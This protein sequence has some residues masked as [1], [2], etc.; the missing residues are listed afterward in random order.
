VNHPITI[1]V[2]V[3]A[4]RKTRNVAL[5]KELASGGA[6]TVYQVAGEPATVVKLYHSETLRQVGKEYADK[7]FCLLQN[8][9]SL[10]SSAAGIIQLSWPFAMARDVSGNFVGFAM[11][12]LDFNKTES[13]ECILVPKMAGQK[14]LRSDLGARITVAANLA[15]VVSAIHDKGHRIVD[16]KPV[17]LRL[18]RQELYVAVLD[19]DGFHV[20]MPGRAF[21]APQTTPEYTAPEFQN[22]H[23]A[24]PE[25]QD[26]FALAV[27]IF[28]LLNFG[29]HPYDGIAKKNNAPTDRQGRLARNMY[30]YGIRPHGSIDPQHVSAHACFPN[31]LR[32]YFDRAFGTLPTLRPT[33][34]EWA[35]ILR[36][37]ALK[38]SAL[39]AQCSNGHWWFIGQKCG[40]CYR[41]GV[42]YHFQSAGSTQPRMQQQTQAHQKPG[43]SPTAWK[44]PI[45]ASKAPQSSYAISK[46]VRS[47]VIVGALI[48]LWFAFSSTES[49]SNDREVGFPRYG[50]GVT[51]LSPEHKEWIDGGLAEVKSMNGRVYSVTVSAHT[52]RI[53]QAGNQGISME[54]AVAAKE[55]L[56]SKGV[57]MHPYNV[58]GKGN[59]EPLTKPDQCTGPTSSQVI[60][61]LAPDRRVEFEIVW[62]K[63]DEHADG[64]LHVD[65]LYLVRM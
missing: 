45:T 19:C 59:E 18:Y 64:A 7:I 4:N 38:S 21:S 25:H 27:I 2:L 9:P 57:R 11:P 10:P 33:S 29:I 44:P 48:G 28:R 35:D 16:L 55:Y 34:R 3:D 58:R 1:V 65:R 43:I 36:E 26:R 22:K 40:A 46:V 42:I 6:G 13:L 47:L 12:T 52:D 17:N 20:N 14:S 30:P 5:G 53:E 49:P 63:P 60:E 24:E 32:R 41:E 54:R 50:F 61:C 8:A 31:E 51:S 15:G 23:I 37:Y 56:V 39:L 62:F